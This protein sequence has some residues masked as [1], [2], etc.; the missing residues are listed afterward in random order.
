[1]GSLRGAQQEWGWGCQQDREMACSESLGETEAAEGAEPRVEQSVATEGSSF[2]PPGLWAAVS[3]RKGRQRPGQRP[4]H[5]TADSWQ[6]VATRGR[7]GK[8]HGMHGPR[9]P[10]RDTASPHPGPK[11]RAAPGCLLC[12]CMGCRRAG[13]LCSARQAADYPA[14]LETLHLAA[15]VT[16]DRSP[17]YQHHHLSLG[18]SRLPQCDEATWG[19]G[20]GDPCPSNPGLAR[21]CF[22]L[23]DEGLTTCCLRDSLT[24]CPR[25]HSP[26]FCQLQIKNTV[27]AVCISMHPGR[28]FSHCDP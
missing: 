26:G 12:P 23:E 5:S 17:P 9:E 20:R 2:P 16:V 6:C 14:V 11:D 8:A 13:C 7:V 21:A 4:P 24:T 22:A 10:G 18:V 3:K 28:R 15:R 1:M 19:C 25:P 27:M